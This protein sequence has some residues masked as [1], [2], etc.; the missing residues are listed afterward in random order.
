MS[1]R[2][3]VAVIGGNAADPAIAAMAREVGYE[4]GRRG[5]SLV[6]GGRG[7]VMEAACAGLVAARDEHDTASLAVGVLPGD[8]R[9]EANPFVD[10]AIPTGI[11]IA[12]NL[13][14][15][16]SADAVIV[17]DGGSGTLSELAFAWQLGRPL[18]ALAASGGIAAEYAGRRVDGRR[19]DL[20]VGAGS[21]A[22]AV[23][24]VAGWMG[25]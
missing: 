13:V 2:R 23:E 9:H 22:E 19:D 17:V 8:D 14:I 6:C 3:L 7:G 4:L 21:A 24:V 15:V 20:V 10:V 25:C 16:R 11:G 5:L 18:V 12:R 1:A